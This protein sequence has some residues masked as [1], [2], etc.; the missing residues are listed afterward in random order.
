MDN[1]K[2]VLEAACAELGVTESPPGSNRVKYNAWYYNRD[3]SGAAYPWC[4]AFVQWCYAQAGL[5][6]PLKTASCGALLR[7]YR[8]HDPDCIVQ[9]S[10][11]TPG[12]VVIFDLPGTPS[13]TDHTGIF[14]SA[15]TKYV[16]TIDGNTGSTN[17]ANGGAVMRRSRPVSYVKAVIKPRA[18]WE[19][20]ETEVSDKRFNTIEE[21]E[22]N[23]PWAAETVQKLIGLGALLGDGAGLDLSR[24]MLRLLVILDRAGAF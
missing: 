8:E 11:A 3:V 21:I 17:D 6:L 2:R 24:D 7:W 5:S 1:G 19:K 13:D 14:E 15:G 23:A 10:E 12:C 18:I 22:Q 9:L 16:T 20:E 4:M